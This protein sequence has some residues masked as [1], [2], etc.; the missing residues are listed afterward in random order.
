MLVARTRDVKLPC[1]GTDRS[2][3]YDFFVPEFTN[4]ESFKADF[5]AKNLKLVPFE[6]DEIISSGEIVIQPHTHVLIPSGLMINLSTVKGFE[7]SKHDSVAFIAFNKSSIA[8]QQLDVAAAVGDED[9]QGELHL[10]I[11]NTSTNAITIFAGMKLVQFILIP[12][13]FDEIEE[14]SSDEVF[15]IPSARLCGSFG[16]TGKY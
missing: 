7:Y 16:H 13:K 14:V 2:A 3:G 9:Y 4:D 12:I 1:R 10:S 8:I 5:Q 15:K 6:V 11:T